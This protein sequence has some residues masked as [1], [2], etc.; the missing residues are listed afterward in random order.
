MAGSS[1]CA[2]AAS[3]VHVMPRSTSPAIKAVLGP[4]SY[5]HL[6]VYKRQ[7]EDGA[8]TMDDWLDVYERHVREHIE[9]MEGVY[10]DWLA[11]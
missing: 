4:V 7:S 5:T 2:I 6:D 10:Q 3:P 11:R 9:Q 8:M 1:R